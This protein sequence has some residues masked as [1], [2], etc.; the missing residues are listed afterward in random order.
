MLSH[1]HG[2]YEDMKHAGSVHS[3]RL[4]QNK[5]ALVVWLIGTDQWFW[6]LYEDQFIY[7]LL[8]KWGSD[9]PSVWGKTRL[10]VTPSCRH[11]QTASF[12]EAHH[13]SRNRIASLW[14]VVM[15]QWTCT[16]SLWNKEHPIIKYICCSL[17]AMYWSLLTPETVQWAWYEWEQ[18]TQNNWLL[19]ILTAWGFSS[20]L[21]LHG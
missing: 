17:K 4:W 16:R 9:G 12:K 7:S 18:E 5:A 11:S 2:N 19:Y 13:W 21:E 15:L 3:D 1:N 8:S 10:T 14:W 20:P 6:F